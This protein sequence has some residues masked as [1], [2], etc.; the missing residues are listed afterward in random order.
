MIAATLSIL[1]LL[2]LPNSSAA[3]RPP[4]QTGLATDTSG[5]QRPPRRKRVEPS[6]SDE[7]Q[8]GTPQFKKSFQ[9][10]EVWSNGGEGL[11]QL[12][13]FLQK[14]KEAKRDE[15]T[16]EPNVPGLPIP[17]PPPPLPRPVP[18]PPPDRK[19]CDPCPE[20]PAPEVHLVPPSRPHHPCPGDHEHY[21]V[22]DQSPPPDCI[23]RLSKRTRCL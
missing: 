7:V 16:V 12:E 10:Q 23:C 11:T 19:V 1:C 2:A 14:L 20:P 18:A 4:Q 9:L 15:E 6:K 8:A 5:P 3:G 17:A 13:L 22:Y 21:F